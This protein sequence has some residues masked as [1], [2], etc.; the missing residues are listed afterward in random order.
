MCLSKDTFGVFR[1]HKQLQG[2]HFEPM[3]RNFGPSHGQLGQFGT[4]NGSKMGQNNGSSEMI[5][6]QLWCTN[7]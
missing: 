7:G 3:L 2:A 6:V 1:V 5:L 4:K